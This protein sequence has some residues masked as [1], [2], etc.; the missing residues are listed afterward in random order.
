MSYHQYIFNTIESDINVILDEIAQI[1][2]LKEQAKR[3][4]YTTLLDTFDW[5]L[6]HNN[7]Y[8]HEYKPFRKSA[9]RI[10]TSIKEQQ[11]VDQ[12][13]IEKIIEMRILLPQIKIKNQQTQYDVLD[14]E[15][16]TVARLIVDAST[17]LPLVIKL[18]ALRGYQKPYNQV[19]KLIESNTELSILKEPITIKAL[20]LQNKK[21][22]DYNTKLNFK[23]KPKAPILKTTQKIQ[24][25]L[26]STIEANINGVKQNIDS[27]FLHDFRVAVRRT[28]SALTQIKGVFSIEQTL[29][30]KTNF[31]EFGQKT[32]AVRDLDVYLLA[33]ND[34]QH[35]LPENF[36]P[37]LLAFKDFL[38]QQHQIEQRKLK[39]FLNSPDFK[40][41]IILWRNF[42]TQ[43]QAQY[44]E[45]SDC[46]SLAFANQ[47]IWKLYKKVKKQGN[48]IN[49]D[50]P[51]SA[52][53]DLRKSCKKLRYI[54]EFFSSLYPSE[55][56]HQIKHLK[57]LLDNLGDFQDFEVQAQQLEKFATEMAQQKALK[58]EVNTYLA[59]GILVKGLI[60]RQNQA[61]ADFSVIFKQFVTPEREQF[62]KMIKQ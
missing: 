58:I 2:Q 11:E 49:Q 54:M 39:Q 48:Q 36:Q 31:A 55:I 19:K 57:K 35:S 1:Y 42:L 24:Q 56:N 10:L 45:N 20:V 14:T 6:Y 3:V 8:L 21:I 40:N 29:L 41:K 53:H 22:G 30:F 15:R 9:T 7:R 62:F 26:L 32:G 12:T 13:E 37:A 52:L 60:E 34:Y 5:R 27:E 51:A 38:I 17:T 18:V 16:K 44:G 25:H 33:F 47:G 61:R 46:P 23:L 4:S 50:S 43:K 28:R 59:M